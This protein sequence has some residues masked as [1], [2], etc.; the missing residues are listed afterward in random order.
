VTLGAT[1]APL[2]A[3]DPEGG[4]VT[5]DLLDGQVPTGTRLRDSGEFTG[6]ATAEG[7]YRALVSACDDGADP[8]CALPVLTFTVSAG[9]PGGGGPPIADTGLPAGALAGL[10]TLLLAAGLA[11]RHQDPQDEIGQL[12]RTEEAEQDE[13]DADAL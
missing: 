1:P 9:A 7:R 6:T 12:A 11:L 2:D 10:A 13:Q 3:T 5:Y 4:A 8:A